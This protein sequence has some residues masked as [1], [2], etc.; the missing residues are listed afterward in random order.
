MTHN[1]LIISLS[2]ALSAAVSLGACSAPVD[3]PLAVD[4]TRNAHF[5]DDLRACHTLATNYK[6]GSGRQEAAV[7]AVLGGVVG[8][9][10]ADNDLEGALV[11]AAIGGLL[12]S[13]EASSKMQDT[14]RDVLVNCMQ[15]RGHSVVG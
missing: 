8:A 14:R 11:G 9:T 6:D 4:G 15:N 10:E 1:S 7:G 12:G 5:D 13:A 3:R 2:L